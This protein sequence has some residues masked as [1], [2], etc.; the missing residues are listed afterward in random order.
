MAISS[1]N[2]LVD[3]LRKFHLLDQRHLRSVSAQAQGAKADARTVCQKLMQQGLL[4]PYQVNQLLRGKAQELLLGSYVLLE[5]LGE[6]GMGSVFKARNWKL[7]TVVAVKMMR[8]E[9]M[10]NENAV[11]RFQREIRSA[12]QL[13]H[14]N[15]V[16]AVDADAVGGTQLFVMEYVDGKD[17]YQSV[18]ATGPL[19][20]AQACDYIRQAACGLAH[21]H[22]NG[23]VHRDIK[24]H[25][26][27]LTKASETQSGGVIKILDFGLT[28]MD[29]DDDESF[30]LTQEGAVVGT[31]DYVSPEQAMNSH[32]VDIRGDLYSLGCTFYF[33]LTGQVPF[34]G[35]SAMEKLSNHAFREPPLV[36]QQRKDV[37]AG[38][39]AVVRKLMA[40]RPEDRFQ[41]PEE[42]VAV[43]SKGP[44]IPADAV[45]PTT[46]HSGLTPRPGALAVKIPTDAEETITLG[47]TPAETSRARQTRRRQRWPIFAAGSVALLSLIAVVAV[48]VSRPGASSKAKPPTE[49][50]KVQPTALPVPANVNII[51]D[52]SFE[53][54]NV[55]TGHQNAFAMKPSSSPWMFTF[56][57]GLAGN[58]SGYTSGNPNAPQGAQ[59]AFLQGPTAKISQSVHFAAGSYTLSFQAAQR[60]NFNQSPQ[61][62]HVRI[63]GKLIGAF[64]PGSSTYVLLTTDSFTVTA[65]PH[66]LS[67]EGSCPVGVD[68]TAFIDLVTLNPATAA[69][70]ADGRM[71]NSI[72][73]TLKLIPAGKFLMGSPPSEPGRL[74]DEDQHEVEISKAFHIG[75][76]AVTVRQFRS[77]VQATAY[78]TEAEKAG[79]QM[80]WQQPGFASSD[81]H[82]VGWVSWH[83]AMAFCDWL[84][85]KEGKKYGLPTEAQWEYSCRA[86]SKTAH[87]FGDDASKLPE[88]AWFKA[89]SAGQSR[90]VGQLKPNAWGLHDMHG[91]TWNWV[92]DWYAADYYQKSPKTDPAGPAVGSTR[93]MRGASWFDTDCRSARRNGENGPATRHTNVSF[94]VVLLAAGPERR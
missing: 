44:G 3:A 66:I 47:A 58:A 81:D 4:T 30:T 22:E 62:L 53:T 11:R 78:K 7:N 12:A 63:D 56:G 72:G 1:L 37:P 91:N 24:P 74:N 48:L 70:P 43:L 39:A 73:M 87:Y 20:V 14:P 89:N 83:D 60:G 55:G 50:A 42:V 40:K 93:V 80:N 18:K 65:G 82:P 54:P 59:V 10:A 51:N 67:F 90:P 94:R 6:G 33:L 86:V 71:T 31:L 5:R 76:Y 85:Q 88:Y 68:T 13:N 21:A 27:L 8:K 19:P 69:T 49:L 64:T 77:F 79:E 38:V 15:I 17:L 28:R 57:G 41:K 61:T 36:E 23:M 52:P 16:K 84:S 29:D 9:R 75:V 32:T 35:G 26:L 46:Q 2:D 45:P 34:T 92:A 25:N